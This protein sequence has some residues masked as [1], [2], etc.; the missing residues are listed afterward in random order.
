MYREM[1]NPKKITSLLALKYLCSLCRPM[2]KKTTSLNKCS[3]CK[4]GKVVTV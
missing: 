1:N 4:R 3:I 2:K